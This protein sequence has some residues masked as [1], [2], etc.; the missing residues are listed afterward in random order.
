MELLIV[1]AL[2]IYF[3]PT[4]IHRSHPQ[5]KAIFAANVLLGWTFIGWAA[6]FVWSLINHKNT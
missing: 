4:C 5:L 2:L 6:I 1:I 3:L